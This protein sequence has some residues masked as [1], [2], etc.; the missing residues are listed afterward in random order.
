MDISI[1][2]FEAVPYAFSANTAD[3]L[4]GI[5]PIENG[6]TNASTVLGA[7]TNL[8]LENVDNTSDLNKPISTATQ[9]A[10]DLK[11][12]QANK[13]TSTTLGTSDV[14]YPTQNAVKTYVDATTTN[15]ATVI[16]NEGNGIIDG[17]I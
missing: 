17:V 13:S 3:N 12:D 2:K 1:Q 7:K 10:L 15:V 11:E 5:L 4:T 16:N 8:G 14:L 6:G 9:A